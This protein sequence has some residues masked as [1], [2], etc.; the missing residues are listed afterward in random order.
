[1]YDLQRLGFAYHYEGC[2]N[3]SDSDEIDEIVENTIQQNKDNNDQT[4]LKR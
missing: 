1:M 3:E 4:V 2:H